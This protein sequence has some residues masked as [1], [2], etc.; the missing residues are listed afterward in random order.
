MLMRTKFGLLSATLCVTACAVQ[1]TTIT[2]SFSQQHFTDGSKPG[3]MVAAH[4]ADPAGDNDT[5]PFNGAIIGSDIT[6]P[7]FSTS[8]TFSYSAP[9]GTVSSADIK[10]GIED[11]DSAA[12]GNQLL[13]FSVNG[14]SQFTALNNLM[15]APAGANVNNGANGVYNV[16]DVTLDSNALATLAGGQ[17]M[18]EL[19]LQGPGLGV[20]GTTT[21]NAAALD[22]ATFTLN[23]SSGPITPEPSYAL[24]VVPV[25]LGLLL[26]R[27]RRRA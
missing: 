25:A 27:G 1:A 18:V 11:A 10:F 16:Y 2:T 24:L 23:Y 12:A 22:F 9:N 20:L 19:A 14:V 21:F 17:A 5:A 26:F 4:L 3:S 7:N 13:T 15:E 8:W 6:G